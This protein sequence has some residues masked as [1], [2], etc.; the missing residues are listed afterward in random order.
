MTFLRYI[1]FKEAQKL[2]PNIEFDKQ[3]P[4]FLNKEVPLLKDQ[5]GNQ[6]IHLCDWYDED[7]FIS[8]K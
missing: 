3:F 8:L 2:L 1:T 7:H 4:A 6:I 5:Y